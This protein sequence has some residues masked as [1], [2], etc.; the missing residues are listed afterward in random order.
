MPKR[1]KNNEFA[2]RIFPYLSITRLAPSLS[3]KKEHFPIF[4]S[5]PEIFS[6]SVLP[7]S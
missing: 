1:S 4:F 5:I 2:I 6:D 7:D 3:E